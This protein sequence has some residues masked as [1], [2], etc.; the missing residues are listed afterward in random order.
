[1]GVRKSTE[2]FIEQA[3][4]VHGYRYSYENC[5]YVNN[6]TDVLIT[7]SIHGDFPQKPSNHLNGKGCP[8][9]SKSG[10]RAIDYTG[11]RYGK[12]T[13]LSR[14]QTPAGHKSK[15]NYWY[16]RCS[17]GSEAYVVAT[18][19][20]KAKARHDAACGRCS[21]LK[22]AETRR[23]KMNPSVVGKRFGRLLALREWGRDSNAQVRIL[24]QCDCGNQSIPYRSNLIRGDTTSCGCYWEEVFGQDSLKKMSEDAEWAGV[25]TYL[26]LVNV[27]N[28]FLKVG[29][30]RSLALRKRV[31]DGFYCNYLYSIAMKR[32]DAWAIEQILLYQTRHMAPVVLSEKYAEWPGRT[33]LR[34]DLDRAAWYQARIEE[35]IDQVSLSGWLS[36]LQSYVPKAAMRRV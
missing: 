16:V 6:K 5:L 9:C 31:S 34:A 36:V 28:E 22:R 27:N 13:V 33:E 15:N 4:K 3:V 23:R 29:I 2:G 30:A 17:C 24:C 32:S 10:L 20:F 1:M 21:S 11:Y 35:L 26:Y 25:E 7:C 8:R 18:T 14:A 19:A 12:L